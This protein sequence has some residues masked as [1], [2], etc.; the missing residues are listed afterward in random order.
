MFLRA[1]DCY[2]V[3]CRHNP[4]PKPPTVWH[5]ILCWLGIKRDR[6]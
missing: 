5:R 1:C 4:R 6:P 2:S 3:Y